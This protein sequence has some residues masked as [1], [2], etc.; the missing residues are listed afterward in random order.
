MTTGDGV[1][2]AVALPVVLAVLASA[3]PAAVG[4]QPAQ[5]EPRYMELTLADAIMLALRNNRGLINARLGRELDRIT[6]DE[7]EDEFRPQARAAID[8]PLSIRSRRSGDD[9]SSVSDLETTFDSS[10]TMKIPTGGQTTF[11]WESSRATAEEV[12]YR[13]T[14]KFSFIQPLLRGGG[15]AV[16]TA[17]LENARRREES[18][19]LAFKSVVMRLVTEVVE[20]YWRLVTVARRLDISARSLQRARELLAVNR[21]LIRTGRMAE[22]DIIQT[23]AN[24]AERELALTEARNTL[25]AARLG[26]LTILDIDSRTR[27]QPTERPA[28]DPVSLDVARGLELALEHRPDYRRA[29]LNLDNLRTNLVVARNERLWDLSLTSSATF[30]DA[31]ESFSGAFAD[32]GEGDYKVGLNLSIPL[33][34][35][36]PRRKY[37]RASIAL[38]QAGNNL[39][40]LRQTI[41]IDVRNAVRNVEVDFQRIELARRAREL[42]RQKLDVEREKLNLGLSTNFQLVDFEDDLVDVQNREVDAIISYLNALT[43]LDQTLGTTL[44]TWGIDVNGTEQ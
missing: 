19:I 31:G 41:D 23:E 10:I 26:L 27:I 11:A 12:P 43:R 21:L 37:L 38:E 40:E 34:H 25:D 42:A 16:G 20:S 33:G 2:L 6:L 4:D 17:D 28:I 35:P 24:V 18:N 29:L 7:V 8:M 13:T 36:G 14:L 44:E 1:R 15:V 32:I 22:R 5:S 9:R 3:S 30:G 39:D